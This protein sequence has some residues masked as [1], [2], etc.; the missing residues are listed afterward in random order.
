MARLT[1]KRFNGERFQKSILKHTKASMGIHK[2]KLNTMGIKHRV[3]KTKEGYRFYVGGLKH[4]KKVLKS[5]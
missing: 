3:V 2:Q 4:K 1:Y 5:W